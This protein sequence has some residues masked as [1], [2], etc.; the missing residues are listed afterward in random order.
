MK[1]TSHGQLL[2]MHFKI[3]IK[4]PLTTYVAMY[5]YVRI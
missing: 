1:I 2:L 3:D 5:S 4:F